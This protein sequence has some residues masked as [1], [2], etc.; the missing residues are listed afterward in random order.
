MNLRKVNLIF[1]KDYKCLGQ[2]KEMAP[3]E[4]ISKRMLPINISNKP[5]ISKLLF[6]EE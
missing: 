1:E 2:A 5:T 3:M 6:Q 4:E